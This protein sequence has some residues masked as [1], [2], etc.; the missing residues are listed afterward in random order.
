MIQTRKTYTARIALD[1]VTVELGFLPTG[2]NWSPS[3]PLGSSKNPAIGE[4]TFT[5]PRNRFSSCCRDAAL[6]LKIWRYHENA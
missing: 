5:E 1:F 2:I 3:R 4:S 6:R